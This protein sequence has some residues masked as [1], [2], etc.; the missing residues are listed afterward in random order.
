MSFIIFVTGIPS[1][2]KTTVSAKLVELDDSF[3]VVDADAAIWTMS[4][5]RLSLGDARSIFRRVLDRIEGLSRSSNVVVDASLPASYVAEAR[6]R[7]GDQAF[8]VSLRITAPVQRLHL[9][10]P[11]SALSEELWQSLREWLE[12]RRDQGAG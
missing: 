9:R 2:G 10:L 11:R 6:E 8:F 12:V 7:F 1:S 5:G 3:G 4:R